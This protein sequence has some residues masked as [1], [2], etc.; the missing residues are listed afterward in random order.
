MDKRR[1]S[2][3]IKV[4]LLV[5]YNCRPEFISVHQHPTLVS[6]GAQLAGDHLDRHA[7]LDRLAAKVG[8]LSSDHRTFVQLDQRHGVGCGVVIAA[9]CLVNGREGK[10]LAFTAE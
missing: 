10:D 9:G 6:V 2:K 4:F 5:S 7:N 1:S 3:L 8:Q